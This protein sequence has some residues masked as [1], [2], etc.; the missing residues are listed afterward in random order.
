MIGAAIERSSAAT[1]RRLGHDTVCDAKQS[2]RTGFPATDAVGV[3]VDVLVLDIPDLND[4]HAAARR[5]ELRIGLPVNT[6]VRRTNDWVQA[7]DSL[8]RRGRRS[9]AIVY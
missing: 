9:R 7:E 4:V 6:T 8:A 3:V 2:Q 1:G 5:A